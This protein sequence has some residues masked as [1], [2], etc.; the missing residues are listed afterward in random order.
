MCSR[1]EID[2]KNM[3]TTK[4]ILNQYP[5]ILTKFI[6]SLS[7]KTTYTKM[8]YARYVGSFLNYMKDNLKCDICNMDSYKQIKPM[9]IDDY[10]E[11]IRYK[12]DGKEKSGMYRAAHLAAISGFFKFLQKNDIIKNNPCDTTESPR[13][14]NEHIITT[15]S[16]EDLD[17]IIDNIKNGVGSQK[18]KSTQQKW[19]SRD[20]AIITLGLT[21]GLRIGAIVGI[22]I[23]DI[24]FKN[25]CITVVEKGDISKKI[26]I[27]KK[28]IKALKT[29]IKDRKQFVDKSEPALFICQGNHRISVRSVEKRFK[30][31][32]EATGK[33]ITPHKM[34]ATCATTLYEQTG[35]IYLV[36]QQLGH[37]SI[38]NTKRYAK[39][40]EDRKK[41]AADI[42]DSLF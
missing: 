31:I 26:Y 7:R 14:N 18:A 12:D 24:D 40:S 34:R 41:T 28:T 17:I 20:I 21:T 39:I 6:N 42:L 1:D 15:I 16:E 29:W 3:E 2:K 38:N 25:K 30:K 23:S 13:D 11:I 32:S 8:S 36:Q 5:I 33:H 4:R 9:D 22:D 37:K 27:G 19:I 10:M 35:D